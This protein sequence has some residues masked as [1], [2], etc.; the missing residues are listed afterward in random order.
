MCVTHGVADA[1]N[2][3]VKSL[4]DPTNGGVIGAENTSTRRSPTRRPQIQQIQDQVTS[5]T[6]YLQQDVQRHG[7]PRQ[8]TASPGQRLRRPIGSR[9]PAQSTK[10]SS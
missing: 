8:R 6:A 1:L 4:L 7:N 3:L 5:Y 9:P 2:S 10:K